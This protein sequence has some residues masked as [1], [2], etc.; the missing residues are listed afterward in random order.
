MYL[1]SQKIIR[2]F[3]NHLE[4]FREDGIINEQNKDEWHHLLFNED[5]YIIG[6]YNAKMWLQKHD[7][8][9]FDAIQ[10][11]NNYYEENGLGTV[12]IEDYETLV[13]HLVYVLGEIWLYDEYIKPF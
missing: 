2:E 12:E 10:E 9:V 5:Y 8:D 6:Y 11:I 7:I 1:L 4:S 3:E 13:N